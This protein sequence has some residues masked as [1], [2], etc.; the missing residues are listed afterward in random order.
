[1][2]SATCAFPT[3]E[4]VREADHTLR[5]NDVKGVATQP[6]TQEGSDLPFKLP[7]QTDFFP[8]GP[9]CA[10]PPPD[11]DN[12]GV[13]FVGGETPV[14]DFRQESEVSEVHKKMLLRAELEER[15]K[16]MPGEWTNSFWTF[17]G[18]FRREMTEI[19]NIRDNPST[20]ITHRKNYMDCVKP[21]TEGT[22]YLKLDGGLQGKHRFR[23]W[24]KGCPDCRDYSRRRQAHAQAEVFERI[25]RKHPGCKKIWRLQF[26]LPRE[27]AE[28]AIEDVSFESCLMD[29]VHDSLRRLFGCGPRS[30]MAISWEIHPC[31]ETDYF[32]DRWHL[33]VTVLPCEILKDKDTGVARLIWHNLESIDLKVLRSEW[34]RIIGDESVNNP[35]VSYLASGSVNNDWNENPE[36][37]RGKLGFSARYD[38]RG[39]GQDLEKAALRTNKLL[40]FVAF[41][42]SFFNK[43]K[44]KLHSWQ[45]IPMADV[46]KRYL[47]VREK[48][49]VGVWGFLRCLKRWDHVLGLGL[50]EKEMKQ[51]PAYEVPARVVHLHR[52]VY[53][54]ESG[55]VESVRDELWIWKCPVTGQTR[56]M[57]GSEM[58][59]GDELEEFSYQG[60][61]NRAAR[62]RRER[63][64]KR[65]SMPQGGGC[66]V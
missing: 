15:L 64:Q 44:K 57:L 30:N 3:A 66:V 41:K 19:L 48:N 59:D 53:C 2:H 60:I 28:R 21:E 58:P 20:G 65:L 61:V 40:R 24:E 31:G 16:E 54:D 38:M 8:D 17:N 18:L 7:K 13:A 27:L 51:D 10:W 9:F 43:Y 49:R 37:W 29:G 63:R 14:Y 6:F 25:L 32:A 47:R 23:C 1:M 52:E 33:H 34:A 35:Q 50:E 5:F 62:R 26:T 55:K 36:L 11:W 12:E 56:Q 42:I 22:V 46:C 45:F 4:G 39:F